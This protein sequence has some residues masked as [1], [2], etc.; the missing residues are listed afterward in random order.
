[1]YNHQNNSNPIKINKMKITDQNETNK[2]LRICAGL[3][4]EDYQL[5]RTNTPQSRKKVYLLSTALVI[6]VLLWS[7][8]GYMI[9]SE[10]L[11]HHW[12]AGVLTA[13]GCGLIIFS[14]ERIIIMANGHLGMISLRIIIAFV[15]ALLGAVFLDLIIFSN[16][17]RQEMNLILKEMKT[18]YHK[19]LSAQL[20]LDMVD[21]SNRVIQSRSDWNNAIAEMTREADG[22]GG[23]R[24]RGVSAVTGLKKAVADLKE[25]VYVNE[26]HKLNHLRAEIQ[27]LKP[28][29]DSATLASFNPNSLLLQ[30]EALGRLYDKSSHV[31]K[32]YWLVTLL[33][34]FLEFM[35]V[36]AKYS[37]P[38]TAYDRLLATQEE[39][40]RQRQ[41]YLLSGYSSLIQPENLDPGLAG[42]RS[43]LNGS[44]MGIWN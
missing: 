37:S 39:I 43:S 38:M 14:L 44:R 33:T 7:F 9:T 31:K 40:A 12:M 26:E 3:L 11:N 21:Q 1:M 24:Q 8:L 4:G 35:V 5:L 13:A 18:K 17:I 42:I 10:V 28:L 36:I 25:G 19:E 2:T 15:V 34:F 30:C 32:I 20:E 41:T 6:P 16:D 23:S 27:N 22:T 29:A